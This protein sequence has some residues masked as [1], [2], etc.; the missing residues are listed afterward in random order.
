MICRGGRRPI[1]TRVS[2]KSPR[3]KRSKSFFLRLRPRCFN[4][5]ALVPDT[6][7]RER[8]LTAKL[9][10]RS[11]G[12]E[13]ESSFLFKLVLRSSTHRTYPVSG[14]LFERSSRLHAV[15]RIAHC[16]IIDITAHA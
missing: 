3:F 10:V 1:S 12:G 7:I 15:V 9:Q 5:K 13:K 2:S 11:Q 14:Q 8:T 6:G 4:S 16:R